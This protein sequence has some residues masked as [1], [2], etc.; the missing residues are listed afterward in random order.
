MRLKADFDLLVSFGGQQWKHFK[1]FNCHKTRTVTVLTKQEAQKK[2]V[3]QELRENSTAYLE[4]KIF[5]RPTYVC[6]CD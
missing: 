2:S 1:A 3:L 4:I 5:P 6:V